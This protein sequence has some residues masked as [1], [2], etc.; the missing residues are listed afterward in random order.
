[1]KGW[2]AEDM[3]DKA[4]SLLED[5]TEDMRTPTEKQP[6]FIILVRN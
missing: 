6:A 5:D 3:K 2:S 1:M 4:N